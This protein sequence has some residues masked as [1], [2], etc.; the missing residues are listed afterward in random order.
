MTSPL[1]AVTSL[2]RRI[3]AV[4][5]FRQLLLWVAGWCV[6]W[7]VGGLVARFAFGIHPASLVLGAAGLPLVIAISVVQAR[8]LS[9]PRKQL[10]ALVDAH[11]HAGGLVMASTEVP[12][13]AWSIAETRSPRV[14]WSGRREVT[15]AT[16]SAAFALAVLLVPARTSQAGKPLEIARDVDRLEERVDVL[17]E[18]EIISE[19]QAEVMEKSLEELRREASGD[20]PAKAWETLDSIDEATSQAAREAGEEAVQ[21]SRQLTKVEAMAFALGSDAV[22]ASQVAAGM[23]DL[24]SELQSAQNESESLANLDPQMRDALGKAALTRRQ[25]AEIGAAAR[26]GK[27]KLRSTLSKLRQQGLIDGKTLRQFEDA[28]N[29]ANRDELARFLRKNASRTS[30][31]TTIGQWCEGGTPGVSRGRADAPMFFG[32]KSPEQ[33][34]FDEQTLPEAAAAALNQ[35]ELVAVSAAAPGQENTQRSSG[36]ALVNAQPGAG[37]A[38]T[39]EVLPRHRG[40]VQRF[41]E[42]KK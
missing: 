29:F 38:F 36:G 15:L 12:L 26:A 17:R 7:G 33:G 8:R 37:S 27:E 35:S 14:A 30:L 4:L 28:A 40:T 19:A 25:L 2:E 32:E 11:S 22:D 16:L 34:K 6:V 24:A 20:D 39:P 41:F 3:A 23:R 10:V 9:P 18:E 42:R 1:P 13:G 5:T 21:Q 31:A